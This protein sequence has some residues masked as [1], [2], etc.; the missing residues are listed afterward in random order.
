MKYFLKHETIG[1]EH[2]CTTPIPDKSPT[3]KKSRSVTTSKIIMGTVFDREV[4]GTCVA[5]ASWKLDYY[6]RPSTRQGR[7][8]VH[9]PRYRG[10]RLREFRVYGLGRQPSWVLQ[11][12]GAEQRLKPSTCYLTRLRKQQHAALLLGSFGD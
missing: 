8:R 9:S 1:A 10:F 11:V 7:L 3:E 5:S 6:A 4:H 2:Y 12:S